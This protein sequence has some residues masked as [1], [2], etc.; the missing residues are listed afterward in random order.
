MSAGREATQSMPL[1]GAKDAEPTGMCSQAYPGS[2]G[3]RKMEGRQVAVRSS[4]PYASPPWKRLSSRRCL[5]IWAPDSRRLG[6]TFDY[7]GKARRLSEVETELADPSVWS[8]S[9]RAGALGRERASLQSVTQT[10]DRLA[11]DAGELEELLEL[12]LEEQDQATLEDVERRNPEGLRRKW[13]SW[14]S[15]ACLA[16]PGTAP[17]RF[18]KSRP[19]PADT[20]HRTSP[21]CCCA[22]TSSSA[23]PTS[24]T[25][26]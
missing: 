14:S 4:V 19:D 8:D 12:A 20:T 18:L 23:R 6:G 15:A 24:S 11:A 26:N 21:K 17:M 16:A 10:L 1:R 5:P 7:A 9:Q 2:K 3:R 13:R 25:R 22:C